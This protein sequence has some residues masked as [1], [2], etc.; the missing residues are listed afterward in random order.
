MKK[1]TI[2]AS[3]DKLKPES[4]AFVIS[5]DIGGKPSGMIAGWT[6]KCSSEPPLYAV[7]LSKRGYTQNL[8]RTSKE[9]VVAIPNKDLEEEVKLFGSTHG[10]IVDKFAES[11]IETFAAEFV[12]SPLIKDATVNMECKLF[13]EVDAG[14][15]YI[16]IGEVVAGYVDNEKKML[17]NLGKIDGKRLLEEF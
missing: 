5:T 16:F 2:K 6:M 9:F 8:I 13:K 4:C 15:H 3:L 17:F 12:K 10:N 7:A 1:T 11:K 14:D